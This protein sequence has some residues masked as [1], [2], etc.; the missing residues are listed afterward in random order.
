MCNDVYQNLGHLK[1][2][3]SQKTPISKNAHLK[4]HPSQK[5]PLITIIFLKIKPNLYI[6]FN[7]M[8]QFLSFMISYLKLK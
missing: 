4:K 7:R 5:R 6:V 3:L 2:P 1:K 8:I